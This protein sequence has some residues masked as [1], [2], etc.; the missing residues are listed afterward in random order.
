MEIIVHT[1]SAG[2]LEFTRPHNNTHVLHD[3]KPPPLYNGIVQ[4]KQTRAMQQSKPLANCPQQPE[5]GSEA[6]RTMGGRS[7]T[8][9]TG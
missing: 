5:R 3:Y 4:Q 8:G 9:S 7:A 2:V 1:P 6:A